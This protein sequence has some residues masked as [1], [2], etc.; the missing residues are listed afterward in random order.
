MKRWENKMH[1]G[2]RERLRKRF[3]ISPDAM[4][5][6]EILE[7]LLTY[8]I[9]RKDTNAIA[10]ELLNRFGSISAVFDS[11]LDMLRSIDGVGDSTALF[12]KTVASTI[13]LYNEDKYKPRSK[14]L[15]RDE[16]ARI[17]FNKFVCRSEEC[18]ALAL[19]NPK[20]KMVFCDIIEK[21][22]ISNVNFFARNL[23]KLVVNYDAKYAIVAHNHPSGLA[24]PSQADLDATLNLKKLLL[25]A[26]VY[27]VDHIIV[28]SSDCTCLSESKWGEKNLYG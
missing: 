9:P 4:E 15:T 23:L 5:N 20:K 1:S 18:L 7:L 12:L 28:S 3:L 14:T 24:L 6:H 25:T 11:S 26:D 22:S 16:I 27:L 8:S 19:F 17:M 10:H 2:H 13:R 21:G